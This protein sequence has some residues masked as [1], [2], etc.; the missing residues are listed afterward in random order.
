MSVSVKD[1]F[2]RTNLT[3]DWD[4]LLAHPLSFVGSFE[5]R[6]R[7]VLL[8]C[9]FG[10][11][12]VGCSNM[13]PSESAQFKGMADPMAEYLDRAQAALIN[14]SREGARQIY[15]DAARAYPTEKQPWLRLA[16]SYFDANDYGNAV[17]AAQEVVARDATDSTAQSVLAVSGL[18]ISTGALAALRSQN[19][20]NRSAK[21]EAEAM[22]GTLRLL[23]GATVLV[24]PPENQLKVV[25]RKPS[26]SRK[27][28][29]QVQQP[30]ASGVPSTPVAVSNKVAPSAAPN[31]F[32][33]LR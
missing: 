28:L 15:R 33:A 3:V 20:L 9:T 32:G 27:I 18:R 14:G 13:R 2:D 16:Q 30:A 24:P 5:K 12:L 10:L 4:A 21:S 1:S 7:L 22:A 19:S 26:L 11:T 31:P 29:P 6:L 17:L 23:L 25:K 8:V